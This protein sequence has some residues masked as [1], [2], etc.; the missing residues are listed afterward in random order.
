M[1]K[2]ITQKFKGDR[3]YFSIVF[4]VLIILAASSII[5]ESVI[6]KTKDNWDSILVDKISVIQESIKKDFNNKQNDVFQKLNIVR[7]DLRLSLKPENESY[8]ELVRLINDDAF[9]NYSIEIFAPNGKL[10]AWN[11]I[12]AIG[13]DELF[14]LSFSLGETY[15]LSKDLIT[16]LSII[17]TARIEADIF[18][19]A[20]STPIEENYEITNQYSGN[21]SFQNFI[22]EKYQ[23]V[24]QIDYTPYSEK[25]KDGRYFSFELTNVNDNKI[26]MVSFQKPL[27][28]YTVNQIKETSSKIQSL[29]VILALIFVGLGLNGDFKKVDSLLLRFI[30]LIIYLTILRVIIF[31]AGFPSNIITGALA[32]SSNFSS[33]FGWGIVKSPIEF[34]TTVVFITVLSIQFFRYTRKYLYSTRK[35]KNK[36]FGYASSLLLSVGVFL[37]IRALSATIKSII[38]DSTI[39]YFREPN[40]LP[41]LPSLGMN[42]NML[43]MAFSILLVLVG[44]LNLIFKFVGYDI[45][46]FRKS[47]L[48][49]ILF[50]VGLIILASYYVSSDP[51]ITPFLILVIVTLLFLVFY[52]VIFKSVNSAY[53]YLLFLLIG[54]VISIS[55]LNYFNTKLERESLK[56]TALEINRV[57]SNLLSF[58]LDETL[59]EFKN[60]KN[61]ADIFENRYTNYDAAAFTVWAKSAMQKESLNSG[62][63]FYDK[64]KKTL[65]EFFVGIDPD[66]KVFDGVSK[67]EEINIVELNYD[68]QNLDKYFAGIIKIA[69]RGITIGYVSAFVSFNIKSIGAVNYPDF[70]ESNLS[71]LNRVIDVKQLKIF[72]FENK[73]LKQVYG[74]IYPSRDQI[75]QI[76]QTKLDGI[77]NDAWVKLIFGGENYE[78]YL[79]KTPNQDSDIITSVSVEEKAFSWNLFNFFKTFIV[80]SLFIIVAFIIIVFSRV[81]KIN[82]TFKSKL[83]FAFLVISI[84]PVVVLALYNAKIVNERAKEGIFS[85]LSQR[86]N[87]VEKHITSQLE[88]HKNRD[89]L[90]A[91]QNAA[92]ELG[93]SFALYS[94]TDQFY[95]SKDIYDK[96]GLFNTKLNPQAYYNLN[97]LRYQEY[98]TSEKLNNYNYDSYYK[99]IHLDDNDYILSVNDA[100]NK[101]KVSFS[102]T[103]INIV[104]F[105]IYSFAVIIIIIISTFFANQI[106]QPIQRL[107]EAT[108][109][110]SKGDLN[111]KIKHKE[112]GELKDLL[113]GF[114][115][116]TSELKKNQIELAEL[117][118]EAAWKEMAK[119]VAHEIKNPLTPMKLALQQL[120]ISYKDKSKDFDKLFEKV[121]NTVL[122]QID[123]LN[124]I[125]SEFSHFA[126]MPSLKLETLDLLIILNDTVNMFMHENTKLNINTQL[127]NAIVDADLSQLEKNVY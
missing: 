102:T 30:L 98:V 119:Q 43:L 33:A 126:K 99:F 89:L 5:T 109:A 104:I 85:E 87:Y 63:R 27:L 90:M 34:F 78:T 117:E 116:M 84:I 29:L 118:R 40:I 26:G 94:S 73:K 36:I 18:Y 123:N 93:I 20:I 23:I 66:N 115:Q 39:R 75:K 60:Q 6:N 50:I 15:F 41:D 25:S 125:A 76:F 9:D 100:F 113:D 42:L 59:R 120:M 74:D 67:G 62:I 19:L 54:S 56:T 44:L 52:H 22:S 96:I 10:I 69:S 80:H 103:E 28:T 57:D 11:Q 83:L 110:V 101:I 108:D 106:S 58:M 79:L 61:A 1:F 47:K 77:Y 14:P 32:D 8:K 95:S 37:F 24:T 45:N 107:T 127:L 70:I 17:D 72:Q 97:Y 64:N 114:N 105:G 121:S 86:A 55:L 91:A 124:Q 82:L 92:K 51:L 46:N 122:N 81:R 2:K 13:Q 112:H 71:I 68:N 65:G 3:K 111:I 7:Q 38:F 4:F 88:K 53:N 12:V 21:T 35:I 31:L 16:Y 48:F 49:F